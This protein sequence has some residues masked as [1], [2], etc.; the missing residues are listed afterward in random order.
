MVQN[1]DFK[2][3]LYR[4]CKTN[5]YFVLALIS[6]REK[7]KAGLGQSVVNR[8]PMHVMVESF[9]K[10]ANLYVKIF[11]NMIS[12]EKKQDFEIGM[13]HDLTVSICTF[14]SF[15]KMAGRYT[16]ALLI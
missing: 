15:M 3:N 10:P 4:R 7:R 13:E 12:K 5:K 16:S 8:S 9:K 14:L 11:I 2:A 1:I 6:E